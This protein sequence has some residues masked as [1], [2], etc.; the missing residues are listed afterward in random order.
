MNLNSVFGIPQRFLT[1]MFCL[2][3]LKNTSIS[4]RFRYKLDISA[5]LTSKLLDIN[6]TIM[7]V[8]LVLSHELVELIT[9]YKLDNQGENIFTLIHNPDMMCN[10]TNKSISN[11]KNQYSLVFSLILI[12]LTVVVGILSR[13]YYFQIIN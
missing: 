10:R 1:V 13:H 9:R 6:S 12:I 8:A 3:H 11:Q 5:A 4:Q 2:I 7:P